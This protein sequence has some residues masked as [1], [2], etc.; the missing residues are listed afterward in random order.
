MTP[1]RFLET[2]REAWS[3]LEA[4]VGKAG[5][6]G[7]ATL[8]GP[9]MHELARLYPATAVDVARARMYGLDPATQQRINRLAI[10][11]HGLLYRRPRRRQKSGILAFFGRDYPRL[12][13]RLWPY[14][15][16]ST[17]IFLT[18]ALG[19]YLTVV[20]KPS[21]AYQFMPHGLE[22]EDAT[23]VTSS[24]VSE[25]YRRIPGPV[26]TSFITTNN[27]KV[28]LAAFALGITAGIGTC[29]M[30]AV[31]AMMLGTFVAH[32]QN[33]GYGYE[34]VSFLT[35]HG[36]LEIFAILVAGAAGLRLGLSLAVPGRVTRKTSLK[37]GAQEAVKLVSGTIPMFI[38]AGA[39]ESFVT[40]SYIAG[41]LKI[42]IGLAALGTVLLYL[43]ATGRRREAH[44]ASSTS[45]LPRNQAA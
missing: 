31:N 15:A 36:A 23:E 44:L 20:A 3:R 25:R 13:R 4:L 29:Y 7:V 18:V 17:G 37:M 38:I 43:L 26:M 22:V 8:T 28:A 11:A 27:V 24:D 39:L 45:A 33:H 16:L 34:A 21:E 12:F 32:F 41:S 42:V 30:L 40:P 9:E 6:R 1:A 14:L 35:P 19:A 5:R 10:A 2:R